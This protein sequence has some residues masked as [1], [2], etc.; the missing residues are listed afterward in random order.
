MC[1]DHFFIFFQYFSGSRA[2]Y[3]GG[4][5]V[6]DYCP[7]YRV[8]VSWPLLIQTEPTLIIVYPLI[9]IVYVSL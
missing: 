5:T 9:I 2:T 8:S 7:Y 4:L 1:D 6:S 3:G